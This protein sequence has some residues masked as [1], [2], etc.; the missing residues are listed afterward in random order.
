MPIKRELYL[1]NKEWFVGIVFFLIVFFDFYFMYVS[2]GKYPPRNYVTLFGVILCFFSIFCTGFKEFFRRHQL[3]LVIAIYP[4]IYILIRRIF[5]P[6]NIELY[7]KDI[8]KFGTLALSLSYVLQEVKSKKVAN[9]IITLV[10]I[11]MFVAILQKL[12]PSLGWGIRF[13]IESETIHDLNKPGSRPAGLAYYT[14]TLAE[15]VLI[16]Y[17]LMIDKIKKKFS[18]EKSIAISIGIF[19]VAASLNNRSMI[20]G[21]LIS[22]ILIFYRSFNKKLFKFGIPI[23]ILLLILLKSFTRLFDIEFGNDSYRV[24]VLRI[25]LDIIRENF[26]LG[27]GENFSNLK[28]ILIDHSKSIKTL[29]HPDKVGLIFPHNFLVNHQL[30]YGL[31]GTLVFIYSI[32]KI[33]KFRVNL[34]IAMGLFVNSMFHNGGYFNSSTIMIGLFI[35]VFYNNELIKKTS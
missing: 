20:L 21:M 15:Q 19:L 8:L 24:D 14:L 13:F 26:W 22:L 11:S 7:Y 17:P 31:I 16:A 12:I 33:P 28:A 10:S 18:Y 29:F 9:I 4:I 27:L 30:K 35:S 1:K 23:F 34:S 5:V 25:S 3:A 32:F 2:W 6:T